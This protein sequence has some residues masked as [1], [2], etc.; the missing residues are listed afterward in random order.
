MNRHY[1]KIPVAEVPVPLVEAPARK[2][3]TTA[4]LSAFALPAK[5][6]RSACPQP[7]EPTALTA[8]FR[9][10]GR[11]AQHAFLPVTMSAKYCLE[12]PAKGRQDWWDGREGRGPWKRASVKR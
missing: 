11:T 5:R 12:T 10:H 8:S 9:V 6:G 1:L 7:Q 3:Q 2:L 4:S